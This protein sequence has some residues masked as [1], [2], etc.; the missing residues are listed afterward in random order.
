V[1]ESTRPSEGEPALAELVKD[2]LADRG[3]RQGAFTT[4][5]TEAEMLAHLEEEEL[6]LSEAALDERAALSVAELER[7]RADEILAEKE[8][9]IARLRRDAIV[10]VVGLCAA[11]VAGL[12][13]IVLT[14]EWVVFA[15]ALGV[16]A[17]IA[18]AILS[19]FVNW[20][21]GVLR[22]RIKRAKRTRSSADKRI[23]AVRDRLRVALVETEI[24]PALR[25]YLNSR[26]SDQYRTTLTVVEQEG[27]AELTEARYAIST[28]AGLELNGFLSGGSGGGSIG[29]AG[30]R[31][32]GKSTLIRQV[33]PTEMEPA[34]GRFGVVVSAPVKFESRDFILHLFAEVCRKI[35]GPD[36]VRR[37][38]QPDALADVIGQRGRPATLR[39]L[40]IAA[41][42][43]P[44]AGAL[45][46]ADAMITWPPFTEVAIGAVLIVGGVLFS[47]F[48]RSMDVVARRIGSG[49]FGFSNVRFGEITFG[50]ESPAGYGTELVETARR[51]LEDIWYQQTFTRGWSGS[52]K[53]GVAEG[54]VD[55]HR[56]LSRNQMTLPDLVG[57]FRGL[58]TA[59]AEERRVLIGIDELDKLDSPK[60]AYSF[61]N[62]M[63]VL[64][65]SKG[66]FFLISV[67][68]DAMSGFERRGLPF[69]DVFDSSFDDVIRVGF[70]TVDESIDLLQ[71]RVVGMP[72]P[73]IFLVHCVGGGLPRDVI[74]VARDLIAMN[75]GA[76]GGWPIDKAC[77][78]V[79]EAEVHDKLT[80]AMVA[81]RAMD[82][83]A[84]VDLLRS[85]LQRIAG[86]PLDG[87]RLMNACR[88]DGYALIAEIAAVVDTRHSAPKQLASELL[89]YL[90]YVAT[91]TEHFEGMSAEEFR[92]AQDA[93]VF[94]QLTRSRQVMSM[95][96]RA[97][98]ERLRQFGDGLTRT[99]PD[100]ES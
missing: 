25:Q 9:G 53:V 96:P 36:E 4:G 72:L 42:L 95:H 44:L 43:A 58:L 65:G 99:F 69:R 97:A 35:I 32:A 82:P 48:P 1:S 5:A 63:K 77:R 89:T 14:E 40:A 33:C 68:E 88:R 3:V 73:F 93:E 47:W 49:P 20:P 98:W 17:A 34:G 6:S 24:K 37:M 66:C 76:T 22:N 70:L 56:E 81:T 19:L 90:L 94:E 55:G 11:I 15:T 52:L 64:F 100:G 12:V 62:E 60:D 57:E 31:G 26:R 13:L 86:E 30:P 39:A 2:A 67:S 29:L 27:L 21:P 41:T 85:W 92:R 79:V 83:G 18:A 16:A 61:L 50:E 23:S 87:V 84:D 78:A 45:L 91:V 75:P 51:Q 7:S 46:I 54:G 8:A 74:R 71:K 59:I 28:R 80:A 38:R 10:I